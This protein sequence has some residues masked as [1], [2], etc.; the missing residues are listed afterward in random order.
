MVVQKLKATV[1][2]CVNDDEEV[3]KRAKELYISNATI[4]QNSDD[5]QQMKKP[6]NVYKYLDQDEKTFV[7]Q[8]AY[9]GQK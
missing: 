2:A 6:S 9:T 3:L 4:F 8:C 7:K 1:A 5:E